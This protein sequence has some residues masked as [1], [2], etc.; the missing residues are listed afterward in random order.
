MSINPP[1][2]II[3]LVD[4][5]KVVTVSKNLSFSDRIFKVSPL[6]ESKDVGGRSPEDACFFVLYKHEDYEDYDWG[7]ENE[8]LEHHYKVR[9]LYM[10][11]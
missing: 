6:S 7:E 11:D 10:V 5:I 8:L 9:I 2:I 1:I 3:I 4:V